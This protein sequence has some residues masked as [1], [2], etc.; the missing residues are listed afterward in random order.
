MAFGIFAQGVGDYEKKNDCQV[1]SIRQSDSLAR[2]NIDKLNQRIDYVEKNINTR[3]DDA[4]VI[5]GVIVT[6]LIVIITAVGGVSYVKGQTTARETA[7]KE[8]KDSFKRNLKRIRKIEEEAKSIL[9]R[10]KGYES[11]ILTI[12]S[13]LKTLDKGAL[14]KISGILTLFKTGGTV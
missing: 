13:N 10:I 4:R 11:S 7:E 5:I 14:D 9:E 6:L 12:D 2:C 3:F 1:K 8:F